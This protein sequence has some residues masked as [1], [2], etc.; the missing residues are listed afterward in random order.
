MATIKKAFQPILTLL[1]IAMEANPEATI[2]SVIN[3]VTDLTSAKTGSGGGK[4]TAFHRDE[5]GEVVA[6]KCYYHKLWMDP[7]VVEFGKKATSPTSMNNMCKDGVSKWTKQ[8]RDIKQSE[9]GLL[10]R[11]TSGELAITDIEAEQERIQADAKIIT[12]REDDYGFETLEE[13]IADSEARAEA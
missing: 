7:R 3:E 6:I 12:P 11:V 4:A 5:N 10:T 8:Q 13:C 1:T 9:A 2:A